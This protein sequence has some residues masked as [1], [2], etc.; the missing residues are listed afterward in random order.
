MQGP[1]SVSLAISE[2]DIHQTSASTAS[3]V[4]RWEVNGD[5]ISR[6]V[7]TSSPALPCGSQCEVGEGERELNQTVQFRMQFNITVTAE[8]CE[9]RQNGSVTV[10]LLLRGGCTSYLMPYTCFFCSQMSLTAVQDP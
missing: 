8:N 2:G 4:L 9:G 6:V 7:V 1:P 3:V 10:Q 5:N